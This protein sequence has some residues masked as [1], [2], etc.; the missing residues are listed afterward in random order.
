MR[1]SSH[2]FDK[3]TH[4]VFF[5]PF[6]FQETHA[7]ENEQTNEWNK[8]S[9]Y[10]LPSKVSDSI[11][12][13]SLQ[14][15]L[16][17]LRNSFF[18]WKHFAGSPSLFFES[19]RNL[20]KGETSLKQRSDR[21]KITRVSFF[22]IGHRS[23]YFSAKRTPWLNFKRNVASKTKLFPF[24]SANSLDLWSVRYVDAV[25]CRRTVVPLLI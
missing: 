5:P 25:N 15:K 24:D 17:F 2:S 19:T 16:L 3:L 14:L 21:I 10:P 12:A 18:V 22:S 9:R 4:F 6:S 20:R 11:D 1:V 7:G 23:L 8:G 13:V